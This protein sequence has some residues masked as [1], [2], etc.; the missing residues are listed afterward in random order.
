MS[1]GAV[2]CV[3]RARDATIFYV[4]M[5]AATRI[6]AAVTKANGRITS[7]L[8]E[9]TSFSGMRHLQGRLFQA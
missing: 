2:Q 1:R 8:R 7:R 4:R 3:G 6:D 5:R 9:T